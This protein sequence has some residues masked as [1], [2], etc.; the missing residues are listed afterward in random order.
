MPLG[1]H[2]CCG[3]CQRALSAREQGYGTGLCDGEA[4]YGTGLCDGCY[5]TAPKRCGACAAALRPGEQ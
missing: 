3:G 1:A 5:E 4:G 2:P